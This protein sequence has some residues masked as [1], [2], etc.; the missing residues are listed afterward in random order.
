M[1]N[2][3]FC[4]DHHFGHANICKF[5]NKDGSKVRPFNSVEEMNE[6]LV[7]NHNKVVRPNDK[8]YM[9]GDV[10]ISKKFFPILERLNGKKSLIRGNHD[11]FKIGE[12]LKYFKEVHGVHAKLDRIIMSHIPLHPASVGRFGIN[13]HGH[14]HSKIVTH[15]G[16]GHQI[17]MESEIGHGLF[18]D[19]RYFSVCMER[20]NYTPISL[21]EIKKERREYFESQN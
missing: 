10:V 4:S 2:L 14:T 17:S 6:T 7:E 13:I 19:S 21:E 12:Y 15:T 5:T 16:T 1:A 9:L 18:E 8:V 11:I 20:I 3:F